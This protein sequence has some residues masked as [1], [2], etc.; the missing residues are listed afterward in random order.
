MFLVEKVEKFFSGEMRQKDI[1]WR[2]AS[3]RI[4][5]WRNSSKRSFPGEIRR[6][7]VFLEKGVEKEGFRVLRLH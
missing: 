1:F 4:V 7:G 5:F 3:K 2:Y 6:K